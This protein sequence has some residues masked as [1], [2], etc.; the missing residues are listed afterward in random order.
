MRTHRQYEEANRI[1]TIKKIIKENLLSDE[2]SSDDY[3]FFNVS[4][5]NENQP[6]VGDGSNKNHFHL[7]MSSKRLLQ[8]IENYGVHHLD[9]TYKI[10]VQGYPLLIYGVSDL[11][12]QIHL[13]AFMITSNETKEDFS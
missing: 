2:L 1:E 5:D 12:G 8:N 3:F 13:I 10:T 7:C 4:F 11:L 6:I 9:C